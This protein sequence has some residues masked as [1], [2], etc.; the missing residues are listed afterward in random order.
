MEEELRALLLADAAIA[1]LVGRR[2]DWTSRPQGNA[3][4]AIV[5]HLIDGAEGYTLQ[6]RDGLF[7][8]RVQVDCWGDTARQAKMTARAVIGLLAGYRGGG[9][10]GVFHVSGADDRAGGSNE[11]DRPFRSRLDFTMNWKG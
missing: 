10:Q 7:R 2:V 8:G 9:F 4:P 1:A 5:L 6:G 11:A 3:L